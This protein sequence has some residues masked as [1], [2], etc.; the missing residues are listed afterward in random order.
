MRAD[1]GTRTRDLHLGKVT[2]YQLRYIRMTGVSVEAQRPVGVWRTP[3]PVL[4]ELAS[5]VHMCPTVVTDNW[6]GLAPVPERTTGLEPAT[7]ALGRRCATNC[8]TSTGPGVQ[9]CHA[10]A[11]ANTPSATAGGYSLPGYS[12]PES[13][14]RESNPRPSAYHADAQPSELRRRA[15]CTGSGDNLSR[16][17]SPAR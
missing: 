16:P 3:T 1:T 13:R 9:C 11:L 17:T 4:R 10:G 2:R 15:R 14:R 5:E 7:L 8:A 12:N 6:I